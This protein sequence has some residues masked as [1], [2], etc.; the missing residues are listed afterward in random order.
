MNM[1]MEA[2]EDNSFESQTSSLVSDLSSD[3][4]FITTNMDAIIF[5]SR[6]NMYK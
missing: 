1:I 4:D 5:E 6:R 2:S 3:D